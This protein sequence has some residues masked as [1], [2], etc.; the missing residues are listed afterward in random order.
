MLHELIQGLSLPLIGTVAGAALVF[1]MRGAMH[2]QLRR[3]LT[4]FVRK[5][6][7]GITCY[8]A[9]DVPSLEAAIEALK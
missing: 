4:G 1:V 6:A 9:E 5:T 7:P 8:S 2:H 3:A